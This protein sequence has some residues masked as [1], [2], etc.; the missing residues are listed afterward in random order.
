MNQYKMQLTK[1]SSYFHCNG[2]LINV[3]VHDLSNQRFLEC[4]FQLKLINTESLKFM[5]TTKD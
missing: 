1:H 4:E 5:K 3:N 2:F